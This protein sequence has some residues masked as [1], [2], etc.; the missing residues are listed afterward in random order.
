MNM[1]HQETPKEQEEQRILGSL[2]E[3]INYYTINDLDTFI[4]NLTPEQAHYCINVAIEYAMKRGLFSIVEAE[5]LSK[6]LRK[7]NL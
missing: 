3:N 2:F 6:S 5:V 4:E 7:L 1:E